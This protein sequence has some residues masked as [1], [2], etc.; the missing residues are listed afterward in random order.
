M[1][2]AFSFHGHDIG[3]GMM[4][5]FHMEV[6]DVGTGESREDGPVWKQTSQANSPSEL[7]REYEMPTATTLG[8]L[9]DFEFTE[10]NIAYWNDVSAFLCRLQIRR[11]ILRDIKTP[12]ANISNVSMSACEG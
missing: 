2:R 9:S 5:V 3:K 7:L 1:R 10:T 6:L 8:V 12:F 4:N 11:G